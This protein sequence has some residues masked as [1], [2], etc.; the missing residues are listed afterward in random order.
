MT[1]GFET[2]VGFLM[3]VGIILYGWGQYRN[4]QSAAGARAAQD[5]SD[6]VNL[7]K[8][9]IDILEK[10]LKEH[11]ILHEKNREEIIRLQEQIKHKDVLIDQYFNIIT[12]RNPKLEETLTDV[13]NFLQALNQKLDGTDK[14]ILE[15]SRQS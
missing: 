4:G 10:E 2:F 14:V 3:T 11:A 5:A 6:T 13:R 12:N 7:L 15:K 9:R 1:S 8:T